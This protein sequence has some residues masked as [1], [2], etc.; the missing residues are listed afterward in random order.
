[1]PVE[2]AQLQAIT[3][4]AK[5]LGGANFFK[6][7]GFSYLEPLGGAPVLRIECWAAKKT[8]GSPGDPN[9]S[10][11]VPATPDTYETVRA[12]TEVVTGADLTALAAVVVSGTLYATIKDALYAY[13]QGKGI[14]PA[15]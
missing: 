8:P 12:W 1:M 7:M 10:P 4:P 6:V 9:A 2:I 14:F 11:P 15:S 5:V 13:L 3:E